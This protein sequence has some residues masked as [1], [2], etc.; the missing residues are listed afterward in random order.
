MKKKYFLRLILWSLFIFVLCTLPHRDIDMD[1]PPVPH[2]DKIAHCGLFFFFAAFAYGLFTVSLNF[3]I[4]KAVCYTLLLAA[5]YGGIIEI[6]QQN[7][8]HRSGDIMDWFAD[9]IGSVLGILLYPLM[10]RYRKKLYNFF[11]KKEK[12]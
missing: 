4:Q 1:I 5:F 2:L 3:S 12:L 10:H 9:M 6:L 7:Y 8:F 11:C